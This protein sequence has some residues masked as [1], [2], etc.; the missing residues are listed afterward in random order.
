MM[1]VVAVIAFQA[2]S[3][4]RNANNTLTQQMSMYKP[5]VRPEMRIGSSI[6]TPQTQPQRTEQ[7]SNIIPKEIRSIPH[8]PIPSAPI[9][10]AS[11]PSAPIVPAPVR[12]PIVPAPT[13]APILPVPTPAPTP[14]PIPPAPIPPVPIPPTPETSLYFF[15]S[16]TFTNAGSGGQFGPSLAQIREA[17]SAVSS[18]EERFI[19]MNSNDGIQLWTVPRTGVYTIRALGACSHHHSSINNNGRGRDIQTNVTLQIGNIIRILVGQRGLSN[20]ESTGGGGG[21]FVVSEDYEPII[22]AGGGGGVIDS[23]QIYGDNLRERNMRNN[24]NSN[25]SS[26][27]NGNNGGGLGG[28]NGGVNGNG[29]ENG[30]DAGSGG[31]G[32]FYRTGDPGQRARGGNGFINGGVGGFGGDADRGSRHGAHGGFGGGGGGEVFGVNL[33]TRNTGLNGNN[34]FGGGGGGYS[35]GGGRGG[36]GRGGSGGGGGSYS[37]NQMI[38]NGATNTDNGR[39]IITFIVP[40]LAPTPTPTLAL[41]PTPAPTPAPE[42]SLYPFTSHTFTN[43]GADIRIERGGD[44]V[45]P[46]LAQIRTAYAGI[47]W[48]ERFI[49][50]NNNNGIQLWTVPRTGVYTIRAVGGGSHN[51]SGIQL[52]RGRDIQTNVTLQRGNIIRILVGGQGRS[53]R[54]STG[55]GGGSFV[56]SENDEPIIVAGG[57]GGIGGLVIDPD[58]RWIS[59]HGGINSNANSTNNGNSAPFFGA[60]YVGIGGQNGDG[61]SGGSIGAGGGGFF[62]NGGGGSF[63]AFNTTTA[64]QFVAGPGTSFINGG[65]GGLGGPRDGGRPASGGFG[66]G[67]GGNNPVGATDRQNAIHVGRGG[68]GGGGGFSG[69]NGGGVGM[70]GGGGGSFS[71][72]PMVDNGA[73]NIGPGRVIITFVR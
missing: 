7:I 35:G 28:S 22:I 32:G 11:I 47:P 3:R 23:W 24:V 73:T 13:P 71:R 29:G 65:L 54:E 1:A 66:G 5:E 69:G 53:S 70:G 67:G 18:W 30:E 38:D 49:N 9:P 27:N 45:R 56:A 31:G 21:T 4:S 60:T 61:G 55:G 16:H 17:Y 26:T 62:R 33:L 37:K 39:V 8:A 64:P 68:G 72:E 25:A 12:A 46:T 57:G 6:I 41:A 58:D 50:M 52:G 2:I 51:N 15:R 42:I 14:V 59:W 48:V 40:A 19:N 10:S 63:V 44:S 34:G 43:A 20:G 36:F